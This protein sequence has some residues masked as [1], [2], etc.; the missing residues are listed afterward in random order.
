MRRFVRAIARAGQHSDAWP[1]A[2]VLVAVLVPAVFLLWFMSAAMRNEHFAARQALADAYR[3][4]LSGS[5][6]RIEGFLNQTT[7][8]LEKLA[9]T[10]PASAAFARCVQSGLVNSVVLLDEQGRIIYP[11][12][13]AAPQTADTELE[14][15]WAQASQVEN[16]RKDFAAAARLYGALAAAVTNVNQRGR[17]IQAQARCLVQAGE[18]DAAARLVN[19]VLG[20]KEYDRAVDPQGRLIAA[21]A[22]LM[23]LELIGDKTAFGTAAHRLKQR[24]IDYENPALAA[25]QRRFLM[26]EFEK[27][28]GAKFPML[29]A[30]ELAAQVC[31][32]QTGL[33]ANSSLERAP[34]PEVWQFATPNRRVVALM[35]SDKL[36]ARLEMIAISENA[37][38]DARLTVEP[39]GTENSAAF[40]S[41]GVGDRLPGWR[42][43]VSLKD[44]GRLDRMAK[45]RTA[46]YLWMGVLLLAG[47]GV[48]TLLA[49]RLL[50]RQMALARLKNDLAATVSHEL[51][52]PLASMRVLVDT[53]LSSE[54]LNE[55]TTREYLQLIAQENERLSRLIQN[56]LTFSRMERN[57]HTFHFTAMP[58][59][60]IVEAAVDAVRERFQVPGCRF[61]AQVGPDLP[62]VMCDRDALAAALINL[63]DNAW[64]YSGDIK[65][66]VLRARRESEKVIFSVQDNGIGIARSDRKRIFQSF[67]QIDQR[68]SRAES[69]CGLGL[70]IVQF[71]TTA[72]DGDVSVESD[73][74]RGSTFTI[75]LPAA[76]TGLVRQKEAIA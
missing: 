71:I 52:T 18:R 59:S 57:K 64:K 14:A 66:I 49:V 40:V 5:R 39:P 51:K 56:F 3:V 63:L 1:I 9:G 12:Q 30:E 38:A 44:A 7:A 35:R 19:E 70:S 23:V 50:R 32:H 74:G 72:H 47:M 68:L 4:Q 26:K 20:R 69:G 60:E 62:I 31:E 58:A 6:E 37:N 25:P 24:L 61:E 8:E 33:K 75:C 11:S 43:A 42:L 41:L 36:I 15:K 46:I 34:I 28:S 48:L 22:E 10:K 73:P 16:A 76:A 54:K 13:P 2:L 53:L 29:A 17:A 65:H 45:H 67:Y 55:Q 21:N 27:S